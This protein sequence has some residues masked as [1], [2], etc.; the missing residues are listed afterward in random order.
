MYVWLVVDYREQKEDLNRVRLTAG[1][2]LIK[3][4]IETTTKT[5]DLTTSKVL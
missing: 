1:G 4:P 5:A 3:Y 2:S